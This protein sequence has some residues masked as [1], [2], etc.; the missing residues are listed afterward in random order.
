VAG[1][2]C[3]F[4]LSNISC[5]SLRREWAALGKLIANRIPERVPGLLFEGKLD[6]WR[7]KSYR[8]L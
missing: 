2:L 7:G 5:E 8:W 3:Y 1:W 4:F 6:A